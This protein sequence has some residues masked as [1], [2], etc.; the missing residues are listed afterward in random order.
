MIGE[1]VT[2]IAGLF[3][4]GG[5]EYEGSGI[6]KALTKLVEG[7]TAVTTAVNGAL[8]AVKDF[9]AYFNGRSSSS[10]GA[11][12]TGGLLVQSI[13]AESGDTGP[14]FGEQMGQWA[15]GVWNDTLNLL[16]VPGHRGANNSPNVTV[17][18]NISSVAQ[19]PADIGFATQ[20]SLNR[21]RFGA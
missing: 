5:G 3:S 20:Q 16:G 7:F 19:N 4:S 14:T 1:V 17:V 21:L 10:S 13:G 8:T 15:E 18:N 9:F 12:G 2:A 6:A 11:V